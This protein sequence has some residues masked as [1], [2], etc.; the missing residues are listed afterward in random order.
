MIE[1][2]EVTY[3]YELAFEFSHLFSEIVK[4]YIAEG[5]DFN[6][7]LNTGADGRAD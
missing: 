6:Y 7:V 4:F 2:V 3:S 5:V 1:G